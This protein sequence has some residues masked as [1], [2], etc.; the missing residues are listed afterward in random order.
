MKAISGKLHIMVLEF[1]GILAIALIG[2]IGTTSCGEDPGCQTKNITYHIEPFTVDECLNCDPVGPIYTNTLNVKRG[3]TVHYG[4]MWPLPGG[5]SINFSGNRNGGEIVTAQ[6]VKMCNV[7]GVPR[8]MIC[9]GSALTPSF[10]KNCDV[11]EH[12]LRI[13]C[14]C[15]CYP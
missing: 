14:V 7:N 5:S 15:K 3:S 9:D 11:S 13:P 4:G 1:L 2:M 8:V 12:R 6:F 10:S